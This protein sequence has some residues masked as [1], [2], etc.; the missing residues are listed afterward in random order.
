MLKKVFV[1]INSLAF[2]GF[3]IVDLI[4][5]LPPFLAFEN[6]VYASIFIICLIL[7]FSKYSIASYSL[8]M[9]SSL[10]IAGRVSRSIISSDGNLLALWQNHV[11][12]LIILLI[13]ASIS[14][15]EILSSKKVKN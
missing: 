15:Y 13:I 5:V 12:V 4:A 6:L 2:L 10:F 9:I 1:V 7:F 11:V 8:A 3:V 14:F